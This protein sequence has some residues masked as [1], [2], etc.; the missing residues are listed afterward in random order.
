MSSQVCIDASV[1]LKLVLDEEDSDK[2]QAL[3]VSW[4]VEDIEAI[5]PCHL[6][7]EVTSVIRH[8]V[9]RRE[10]SP[11]AG[12]LAFEA[13]QAQ[14]IRLVRPAPLH[15]RAWALAQ[16]FNRPTAYDAYYLALAQLAGCEVWTADHRLYHAVA[17]VLQWVK[18]LGDYPR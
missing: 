7:F 16:R 17:E 12:Q 1:A 9:Y 4:V 2:A 10:I 13:L 3:W 14:G 11:E 15:E 8:H 5:A 18:W 6:A